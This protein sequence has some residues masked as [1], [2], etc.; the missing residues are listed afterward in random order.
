MRSSSESATRLCR[1]V[2]LHR[3]DRPDGEWVDDL[4]DP[5]TDVDTLARLDRLRIPPAWRDVWAAP[6]PGAKVQATGV[7]ARG[8][9]QYRYSSAAEQQ[10]AEHKFGDLLVF[11]GAL[12]RLRARVD[13]QL[14]RPAGDEAQRVQ[15]VTAAAVRLID[16]G[17][18]RVGSD[19]YARDNHT[20]GLT[21]LAAEHVRVD[22]SEIEFAFVGKE[23]RPWHTIVDDAQAAAVVAGL[24]ADASPD[25][26]L[27]SVASR[28][29]RH[30]VSSTVVNS[31][32]HAATT[33]PATAKTFRTWGG[34]AA[35]AGVSAG[36][37][38]PVAG[39]SR[40]PE[41]AA[42]DAA[43][44]VLGNTRDV[45]RRSYVHPRAVEAGRAAVVVDAVARAIRAAGSRDIRIVLRDDAVVS[46]LVGELRRLGA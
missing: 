33:A 17:L 26:P 35:A 20:Y 22:G 42:Y 10:A 41:L 12:P 18:F 38:A 21:T 29:G 34:T 24:L 37:D 3:T 9:T 19:R 6:D 28:G 25:A 2:G 44:Y 4:G 27:F 45:A 32:I 1:A 16:R 7:D 5:V 30:V 13:Q 15:R 11:G 31:Y 39:Q 36:A 14:S 43:A 40:R 23:H 8:R 46:A